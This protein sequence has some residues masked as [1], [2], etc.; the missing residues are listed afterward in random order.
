MCAV[1]DEN[2][3]CPLILLINVIQYHIHLVFSHKINGI[4]RKYT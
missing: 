1:G 3:T 4:G 2:K